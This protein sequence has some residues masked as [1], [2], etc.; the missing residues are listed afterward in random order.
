[1]KPEYPFLHAALMLV[2]T[3]SLAACGGGTVSSG[4]A[5]D[6]E[7]ADLAGVYRGTETLTLTSSVDD[8]VMDQRNNVVDIT[9]GSD[10]TLRYANDHGSRGEA[11]ITNDGEFSMRADARTHFDGECSAGTLVLS[12]RLDNEGTVNARYSSRELVCGGRALELSG[13][14]TASR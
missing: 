8:S 12:G 5:A 14:L 9:I 1:M 4:A 10:G 7:T 6:T 13:R 3:L 2:S 11:F